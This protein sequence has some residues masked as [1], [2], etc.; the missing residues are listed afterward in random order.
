MIRNFGY[1]NLRALN[2]QYH[3][4]EDSK[5]DV[6]QSLLFPHSLDASAPGRQV[7]LRHQRVLFAS[8]SPP[9]S[10]SEHS[11]YGTMKKGVQW[12]DGG[13]SEPPRRKVDPRV[14]RL[15][16][17]WAA[18][19]HRVQPEIFPKAWLLFLIIIMIAV[20]TVLTGWI[21]LVVETVNHQTPTATATPLSP[22]TRQS[23]PPHLEA[24]AFAITWSDSQASTATDIGAGTTM[25]TKATAPAPLAT[26]TVKEGVMVVAPPPSAPSGEVALETDVPDVFE[27]H[28]TTVFITVTAYPTPYS[29]SD[30]SESL[31]VSAYDLSSSS[32]GTSSSSTSSATSTLS[33]TSSA[34]TT[35]TAMTTAGLKYCTHS[36]Q[37]EVWT[38]CPEPVLE[39]TIVASKASP[40]AE[41]AATHR[42]SN[43]FSALRVAF[44]SLWNS[45]PASGR[46][47]ASRHIHW[48]SVKE[49][50]SCQCS[51][52][53]RKLRAAV[54]LIRRQQL[55]MD[56]QEALLK[57]HRRAFYMAVDLL[58]AATNETVLM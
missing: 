42:M 10:V 53:E 26:P 32:S 15:R 51:D 11:D 3:D 58:A 38:L 55:I 13:E 33:T 37:P 56:D 2:L 22:A 52:L 27:D 29:S 39:A 45:I 35:S 7:L 21:G 49:E 31:S 9:L 25:I 18:L 47:S 17:E 19:K 14:E 16:E 1:T 48:A 50:T 12:A 54:D 41:S 24:R 57:E 40:I 20:G 34:K 5:R 23:A 44:A 4:E 8:P 6:P 46:A 36:E 30:S 28:L 43:P